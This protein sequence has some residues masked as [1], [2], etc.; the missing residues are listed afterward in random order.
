VVLAAVVVASGALLRGTGKTTQTASETRTSGSPA[1]GGTATGGPSTTKQ[2]DG[3]TG[4]GNAGAPGVPGAPGAA[5]G[6]G[7]AGTTGGGSAGG[8]QVS[9]ANENRAAAPKPVTYGGVA[10]RGCTSA[11]TTYAEY[12]WYTNGDAGWWTLGGALLR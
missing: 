11:G 12:G 8:A 10:G 3:S 6:A 1:N 9:V 5:I 2:Q 7:D 4:G